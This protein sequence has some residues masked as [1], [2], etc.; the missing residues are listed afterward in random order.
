M[1]NHEQTLRQELAAL[2]HELRRVNDG[3]ERNRSRE[4]EANATRLRDNIALCKRE[5]QA[6][7]GKSQASSNCT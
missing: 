4:L 2:E 6:L 1:D 5:L 3:L 7:A